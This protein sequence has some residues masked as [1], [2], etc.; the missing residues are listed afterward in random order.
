MA[1]SNYLR[2]SLL[3]A[4]VGNVAYTTPTTVYLALSTVLV[5][6]NTAPTEITGNNYSRQ[7]VVFGTPAAG[8]IANTGNVTFAA[9]GNAWPTVVSAA[10]MDAA[11]G[12][13]VLYYNPIAPR[14]LAAGQS[15]VFEAGRVQVILE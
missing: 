9:T 11:T 14:T 7:S 12:G 3:Q 2:D 15:I 6:G 13:N 10:V 5:T 8:T 4:S 1:I